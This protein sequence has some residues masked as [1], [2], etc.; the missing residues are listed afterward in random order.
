MKN[1]DY[2][3]NIF[4]HIKNDN[5]IH[6]WYYCFTISFPGKIRIPAL[7]KLVWIYLQPIIYN[8]YTV[9]Q[10]FCC[11]FIFKTINQMIHKIIKQLIGMFC[12]I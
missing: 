6:L 9:Q 11:L 4:P 8:I 2:I 7:C 10:M 5:I 12:N 3:Y 1:T